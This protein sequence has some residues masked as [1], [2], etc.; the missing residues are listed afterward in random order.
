MTLLFKRI[1]II[2]FLSCSTG[3]ASDWDIVYLASF[4]RSGN[5]WVR[6]LIEEASC[7]A[8]SS[9]YKDRDYPHL[10][11]IFPWGG[12][13]TDRG[14]QGLCRYPEEGEP[15]ALKTHYPYLQKKPI[16][17]I[18]RAAICLIRHPVDAFYSFHVYKN[19]QD[20]KQ[21]VPKDVL[22][23]FV[24][25]WREFY[26][27]WDKQP[28]VVLVRY[29]DLYRDPAFYLTQILHTIGYQAS[30]EDIQR[31]IKKYPPQGGLLKHMDRYET[32]DIDLIKLQLSDLLVKYD[33]VF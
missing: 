9:T 14:Y 2:I 25:K 22:R 1:F 19:R 28:N 31:A 21:K 27:F 18:K 15:V 23:E 6:F 33:Y 20:T 8:T 29:E 17:P 4:P 24:K 13:A 26:E 32:A 30:P 11:S 3:F 5:H 16:E 12:Y 10:S 7:I